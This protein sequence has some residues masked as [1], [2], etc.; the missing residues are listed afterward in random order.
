MWLQNFYKFKAKQTEV[1]NQQTFINI[2][3]K[4]NLWTWY[5]LSGVY[6]YNVQ[7]GQIIG[8]SI[9]MSGPTWVGQLGR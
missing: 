1:R 6:Y 4:T 9:V 5:L 3:K 8:I 7:S 2:L